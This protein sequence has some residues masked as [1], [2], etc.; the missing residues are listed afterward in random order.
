MLEELKSKR[1]RLRK[2]FEDDPNEIHLA[3]EVKIIDDKIAEGNQQVQHKK[4]SSRSS[5]V[6]TRRKLS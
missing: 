1:K 4:S 5:A 3:L 6:L 2:R